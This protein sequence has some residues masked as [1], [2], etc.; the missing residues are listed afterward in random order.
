MK[1]DLFILLAFIIIGLNTNLM[2]QRG[3]DQLSEAEKAVMA[4]IFQLFEGMRTND[5]S[6]V[7]KAFLP[8]AN[9]YSCMFDAEN[10]P[11]IRK[12]D[13]QKFLQF[14]ASPKEKPVSEPIWGHEIRIDGAFAQV[15]TNYN[16]MIG[17]EIHHCGI[18]AFHLSLTENGWRIFHVADTRRTDC[19]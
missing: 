5:S 9:M 1:R 11:V 17:D 15:W 12:G 7:S 8:T 3:D 16:L 4:P 19:Q 2:A 6:M 13:L 18:D 14:I 10:K